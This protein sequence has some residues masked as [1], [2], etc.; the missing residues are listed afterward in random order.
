M[1]ISINPLFYICLLIC[2]LVG[3]FK[4]FIIIIFIITIHELGHILC[5]L[6]FK[7]NISKIVILPF[8]ELTIFDE[9][10]DKDLNEELLI[11]LSGPL[12]QFIFTLILNNPLINKISYSILIYNLLPLIPLDGSKILNVL[13]NK[14]FNFKTSYYLSIYI[15]II[16]ICL[17]FR[18]D[19]MTILVLLS[20]IINTFKN[21]QLFN[22]TFDKFLL[23]KYLYN[24]KFK[25]KKIINDIN[26]MYKNTNH[27]IYFN[28]K[29][30]TEKEYLSNHYK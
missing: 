20:I 21:Y 14:I 24:I 1:N 13:F 9:M 10:I 26:K 23:E 25:K 29:Y 17:C 18:F 2:I 22:I 5:A 19:L 11:A 4:Y 12:L 8:G 16:F 30:I 27:L 3:Y 7:W 6:Y 15:S 28:N